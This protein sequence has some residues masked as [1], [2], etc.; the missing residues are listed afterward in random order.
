[1]T[2]Y[3]WYFMFNFFLYGMIGW[4]I[5]E[6]YCFAVT[7][8]FQEDGF[9]YGPFK[10]MYAIAMSILIL[11]QDTFRLPALLL[12]IP[13]AI[14]PTTVE[15]LSGLLTR[16]VFHRDY[17][18]YHHL[19]FNFQG[20]ICLQFSICWTVLTYIG[21]QYVQPFI[22]HFYEVNFSTWFVIAPFV[23]IAFFLDEFLTIRKHAI[24]NSI[25]IHQ[26][27]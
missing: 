12:L 27:K 25:T 15:Y 10:P 5:E 2:S 18:D 24:M 16:Y 1:M 8:H 20:L 26:K 14:V 9:L 13:C 3:L 11:L 22:R 19:K 6:I 4:I 17:W 23:I 7:G 21:I